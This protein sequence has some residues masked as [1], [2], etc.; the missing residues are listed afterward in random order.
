MLMMIKIYLISVLL[1]SPLICGATDLKP[2]FGNEYEA[3]LRVRILYQNY[4]KIASS[5]HHDFEH[6]HPRFEHDL[7]HLEPAHHTIKDRLKTNANDTFSTV[8]AVYP[9]KRYSGEFEITGA[10]TR[11]QSARIDNFR[12]TGRYQWLS[13]DTDEDPFSLVTSLTLTEPLSRALHDISSFHHGHLEGEVCIS[14]GKKYGFPC[15]KDYVFRWW[16]VIGIGV[17][18]EGSPW[19]RG[20]GACEYKYADVHIFRGFV[21]T[22][23]GV[24]RKSLNPCCF[25]G[26]GPINHQSVD[27]GMRYGYIIDDLGTLSIQYARRVYARNFPENANLILFEFYCPFGTQVSTSY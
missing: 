16:N 4:N 20:D 18:E 24:G 6:E 25:K 1:F 2:W 12:I 19:Y 13:D 5:S 8:S 9:F 15:S 26:Y 27:V 21:H 22:L 10:H 3:E 11:H 23:W 7:C 17:A 14:Y